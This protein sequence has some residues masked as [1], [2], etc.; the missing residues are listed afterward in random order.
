MLPDGKEQTEAHVGAK[1]KSDRARYAH[2]RNMRWNRCEHDNAGANENGSRKDGIGKPVGDRIERGPEWFEP[3]GVNFVFQRNADLSAADTL[4]EL[5]EISG[6][7]PEKIQKLHGDSLEDGA[8]TAGPE[9]S[10]KH[11]GG[12]GL[13]ETDEI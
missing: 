10:N 2:L 6:K 9:F 11:A 3:L 12:I 1:K 4:V 13:P 5:S 8:D 7:I